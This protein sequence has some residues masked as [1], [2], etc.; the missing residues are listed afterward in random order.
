M[1]S[2]NDEGG[3]R[4]G[5]TLYE[6]LVATGDVRGHRVVLVDDML[7][8]GGHLRACAARLRTAGAEPVFAVCAGRADQSQV[9][10][11]FAVRHH[12]I[13]DHEP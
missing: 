11:P 2:A 7:T 1:A 6:Y 13:T 10:D 8:S 3:T 9:A 12:E 5:A 4:D